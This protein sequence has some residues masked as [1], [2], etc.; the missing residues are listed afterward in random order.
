MD[1]CFVLGLEGAG[2]RISLI[3]SAVSALRH[4]SWKQGSLSMDWKRCMLTAAR[5]VVEVLTSVVSMCPLWLAV[6]WPLAGELT[7][8][9]SGGLFALLLR[10]SYG[11]LATLWKSA[12]GADWRDMG[13]GASSLSLLGRLLAVWAVGASVVCLSIALVI[14]A[15]G[16]RAT[17]MVVLGFLLLL[18]LVFTLV[19]Y[20]GRRQPVSEAATLQAEV[21]R[22]RRRKS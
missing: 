5:I 21:D 4:G 10:P 12:R 11:T 1:R 14:A 7:A 8:L 22:L 20:K 13:R 6:K 16:P 3:L 15:V 17:G 2:L 18:L 19:P 9:V